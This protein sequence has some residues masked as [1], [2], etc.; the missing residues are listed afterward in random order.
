MGAGE[1]GGFRGRV[2]RV[3]GTFYFVREIV[4]PH[5]HLL[6]YLSQR[7]GARRVFLVF[8]FFCLV[9]WL[10]LWEQVILVILGAG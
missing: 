5:L 4:T 1:I 3:P 2:N 9:I 6:F 7:R 10:W 8:G